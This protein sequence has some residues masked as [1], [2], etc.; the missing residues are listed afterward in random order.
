MSFFAQSLLIFA[1]IA[2]TKFVLSPERGN[3]VDE[4]VSE[5]V[6]S[7]S[8]CDKIKSDKSKITHSD[9]QKLIAQSEIR[10][11]IHRK[12]ESNWYDDRD[13]IADDQLFRFFSK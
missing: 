4:L 13:D 7:S 6:K 9:H 12:N 2:I 5:N 1:D 8:S 11:E 3:P 10:T